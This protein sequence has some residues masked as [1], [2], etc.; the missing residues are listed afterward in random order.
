VEGGH[1]HH[2]EIYGAPI[3]YSGRRCSTKV[4]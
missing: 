2:V 1:R 4:M 3:T